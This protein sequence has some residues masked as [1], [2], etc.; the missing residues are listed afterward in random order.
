MR[1]FDTHC[2]LID[3]R[4]A[5]DLPDVFQRMRDAEVGYATVMGDPS[6][7]PE[8]SYAL[9][10]GRD[11]LWYAIGLHPH[12]AKLLDG[13][14]L[15]QVRDWMGKPKVV[16]LGEIGLDYHYE[17]SP[18]E[19]QREAL[20]AQLQIALETRKPAILHIREAHG[21]ATDML[22]ARHR[23][24]TL[25]QCILHCYSGSWES[26]KTY[27]GMGAYLSLSGSATFKN[28]PKLHEVAQN[29]PLDLLLVETDAPYMAPVPLRGQR[30]EPAF[31]RQTAQFIADLR[32]IPLEQLAEATTANAMYVFGLA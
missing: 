27:L 22:S 23:A 19:I 31:V 9:A 3:E 16:G 28:A 32:G 18:R 26:A 13:A 21:D 15:A 10:C 5:A 24:G 7:Q 4:F 12:N 30:N 20:D 25:P 6:E 2:H 29:C 1:L 11:F 17:L 14:V 8:A